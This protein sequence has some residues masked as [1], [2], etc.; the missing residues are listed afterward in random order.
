LGNKIDCESEER[1]V[2]SEE[3]IQWCQKK[4]FPY[5]ETSAKDSTNLETSFN[6]IIQKAFDQ[7]N[8]N[9]DVDEYDNFTNSKVE[10][11]E[12]KNNETCVC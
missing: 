5:F 12:I 11:F 10:N 4:N 6:V 3:A 1:Q 2:S 7:Q 8:T 9:D